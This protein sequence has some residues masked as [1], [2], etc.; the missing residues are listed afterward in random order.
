MGYKHTTIHADFIEG[1]PRQGSSGKEE[2]DSDAE[3]KSLFGRKREH[4]ESNHINT[5]NV[6]SQLQDTLPVSSSQEKHEN[7]VILVVWD[8][9]D[10]PD[11]PL[12]WPAPKKW[13]ITGMLC[14]MCLF[15]GLGKRRLRLLFATGN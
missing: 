6:R 8:G 4:S 1:Q 14:S 13:L 7:N 10:D 3:K 2:R 12:N 11:N 5:S 15:I 9:D